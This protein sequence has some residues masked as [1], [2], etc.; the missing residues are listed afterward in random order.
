MN[1]ESIKR[2]WQKTSK[3]GNRYNIDPFY[4]SSLWHR[5]RASFRRGTTIVNG[6]TMSNRL[7]IECFKLGKP[8]EGP[9]VDH[10]QQIS[11]GGSRTD[12]SNLQGLCDTHHARKSAKEGNNKHHK[13]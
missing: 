3:H 5:T 11:E 8:V 9:N 7:C 10:I 4:H 12:H 1:I 2:P 13:K 6:K